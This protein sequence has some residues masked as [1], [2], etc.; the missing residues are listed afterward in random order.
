MKQKHTLSWAVWPGKVRA[1]GGNT[2][3]QQRLAPAV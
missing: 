2:W 1:F 3:T